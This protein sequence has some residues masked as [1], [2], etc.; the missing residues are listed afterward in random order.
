MQDQK[1]VDRESWLQARKALLVEEKSFTRQRDALSEKRR[2]LPAVRIDKD[3]VF[4]TARGPETLSDLFAGKRQLMI[5]HF[6]FPTE[7]DAGCKS[8]SFWADNFDGLPIHLAAREISFKLVSI[9]RLEKLFEFRA[10]MGWDLDW[11]SS[12][13]SDFNRDFGVT[14]DEESKAGGSGYNYTDRV[15]AGELPGVSIFLKAE[16][17][18]ILHTY[19]T[20][21]RGLDIL[22]SAYNL[23]DLTPVGRDEGDGIMRWLKLS[24]QYG[25]EDAL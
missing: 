14:F 17:G 20:Y 19:S 1:V 21:G 3:Y 2:S 15:P 5:Y 16:D 6:M 9:G 22:N 8:C 12:E 18:S 10:R 25:A 4:Q 23:I 13:G 11:V 24:D 7:W